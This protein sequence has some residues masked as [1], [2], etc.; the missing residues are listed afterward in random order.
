MFLD[1]EAGAESPTTNLF[2]VSPGLVPQAK[3]FAA[4]NQASWRDLFV[5]RLAG[6]LA[7]GPTSFIAK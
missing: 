7:P 1:E 6:L 2:C 5:P 4:T 3:T